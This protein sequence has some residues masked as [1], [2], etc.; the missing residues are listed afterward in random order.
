VRFNS[1]LVG[2]IQEHILEHLRLQRETDPMLMAMAAT[3]RVP[4]M[5]PPGA[6]GPPMPPPPPPM[7]GD[8]SEQLDD[9]SNQPM[10]KRSGMDLPTAEVAEPADDLLGRN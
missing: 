1:P 9:Q 3:G 10:I 5:P 2:K 8:G 6:G 4:E 7:E